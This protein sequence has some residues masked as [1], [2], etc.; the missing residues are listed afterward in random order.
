MNITW[1]L[2]GIKSLYIDGHGKIGTGEMTFCPNVNA[3]RLRFEITAADGEARAYD[4]DILDLPAAA[5]TSLLLLALLLP[6]LIAIY[7]LTTMRLAEP[8]VIG[9][10]PALALAALLLLCLLLQAAQPFIINDALDYLAELFRGPYWRL[11]GWLMAGLVFISIAALTMRRGLRRADFF[12]IVAFFVFMLLLYSPFGFNTIWH[13]E[14]WVFQAYVEGQESVV[15]NESVSRFWLFAPYPLAN[16]TNANPFVFSHILQV[17]LSTAKLSLLYGIVGKLRVAPLYAFLFALFVM[18]YPVNSLLLSS[19]SILHV[20]S[21][22]ALLAAVYLSLLQLEKP[23]RAALL[24][25]FLALFL[26]V[27][28]YENAYAIIFL[29]PIL[30]WWRS[31]RGIWYKFHL[32]VTWYL[33]P[34]AKL[35]YLF[36]LAN[37]GWRYY[38]AKYLLNAPEQGPPLLESIGH[39]LGVVANVY[40]Q[41]FSRGWQEAFNSL[42]QNVWIAPTLAALLLTATVAIYLARGSKGARSPSWR[43]LSQTALAGLLFILPA[44]AVLMW[45]EPYQKE[46][47]RLYTYV[48]IGA[49]A[50]LI[51]LFLLLVSPIKHRRLR[52]AL[53]VCLCLLFMIPALSRLFVQHAAIVKRARAKEKILLQIVDQAPRFDPRSRLMI[54][55]S[56]SYQ[57][58]HERGIN[59]LWTNMLDSA[60]YMLYQEGRPNISFLCRFGD[61]CGAHNIYLERNYMERGNDYTDFVMFRLYDDL[62]VELLHQLPPELR[63]RD[64]VNYDPHSLIDASAPIPQRAL[65]MMPSASEELFVSPLDESA[66]VA[67]DSGA[68]LYGYQLEKEGIPSSFVLHLPNHGIA[69]GMGYSIHLVDQA[70]GESV[71]GLNSYVDRKDLVWPERRSF[72]PLFRQVANIEMPPHVPSNRA[73]W[74][75]LSL[76]REEGDAY[77]P[78]KIVSSDRPLLGDTQVILAEFVLPAEAPVSASLP[79]AKFENGFTLDAVDLP[80][81]ARAGENLAISFAWRADKNG[82]EDIVQFLHFGH[83]E[84]GAWWA[85]DQQPLGARLPTRLWYSGLADTETWEI[86]LPAELRPGR[87]T[88]YTGLYRA[89]DQ[90]RLPAN[91]AEGSAYGDAR[92]PLGIL[93]VEGA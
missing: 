24:G 81:R 67:F 61:D 50:V 76:W 3:T 18:L 10:T 19:R 34:A 17:V 63:N 85:Y 88:V 28:I 25:M 37:A 64:N 58:L 69:T 92:V 66:S 16:L 72:V 29:V 8:L 22:S 15:R 41:T 44:I 26:C 7:Y 23:N 55:T 49:A 27:G 62:R 47:W 75:V 87:H 70:S 39:Y 71:A 74:T 42:S 73:F 80:E 52:Q 86:R 60:I 46:L 6:A 48:P 89:S 77:A 83:E 36:I 21:M 14:E 90:V 31:P 91:D 57:A 4:L 33:I 56:M 84:S 11:S 12:V 20:Y 68:R 93:M 9:L 40:F 13:W 54:V 30:W 1:R 38:G 43:K 79:A 35:I 5:L 2:E 59:E 82:L 51:C 53:L 78:Q 65:V 45:F 32:T